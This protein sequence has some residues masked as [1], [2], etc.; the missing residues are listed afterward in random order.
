V[1]HEDVSISGMGQ[2]LTDGDRVERSLLGVEEHQ[3]DGEVLGRVDGGVRD[4]FELRQR[5][6]GR[7]ALQQ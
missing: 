6:L 5:D 2:R 3:V 4:G 1:V 7:D